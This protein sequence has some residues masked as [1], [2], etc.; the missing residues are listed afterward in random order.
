MLNSV[1]GAWIVAEYLVNNPRA[2]LSLRSQFA[3]RFDLTSVVGMAIIG[4]DDKIIFAG[5]TE[6]VLEVVVGLAGDINPM[7]LQHPGAE[8]FAAPLVSTRQI[9]DRIWDPLRANFDNG[10]PQTGKLLRNAIDQKRVKCAHDSEL[11][12]AKA[13]F[14]EKK[15]IRL[16]TA[17]G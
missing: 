7:I 11:E 15:V 4:A 10:N 12:F 5:I 16:D 8:L 13:G 17:V 1:Q 3:Q 14:V 2:D 6:N 9:M